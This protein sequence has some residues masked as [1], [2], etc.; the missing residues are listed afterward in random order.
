VSERSG[1]SK[2]AGVGRRRFLKGAAVGAAALV[3]NTPAESAPALPTVRPSVAPP[4]ETAALA[5]M[6]LA[7][8]AQAAVQAS[9]AVAPVP[10]SDFMVDVLKTLDLDY[11]AVNPG[12]AFDGLH[13]SL[14]NYGQNKKPE[15]L[16]CLHEEQAAAISH[17][18]AKAA[19][20][21]MMI[22]VHGTVGLLHASFGIFQAWC[23][24]VPML[25]IVGHNR[26]PTS[27]I[28]RPHSA[29]DMGAIARDYTKWDDEATTLD[30][31]AETAVKAYTYGRTPPMGPTLLVV[32][33]ALQD[34]RI[35]D[36]S[37][38]RIPV[39][40]MPAPPQGDTNAVK[41]AARFLVNAQTPL[42]TIGK[43]A[44]TPKGWDLM[45]EL[46]ELL[47]APVFVGTYGS[48]QDFPNRHKLN[49]RGGAGYRPDVTLGL[50]LNDMSAA[51]RNAR[52]N[53]GKTISICAEYLSQGRN[54]HDYGNYSEVDLA[55]AADA[56]ATLPSLIEEIR[57]LITPDKRTAFDARGVKIAA[58]HHEERVK[59]LEE[60]RFGWDVSPISI[61][62]MIAELG[63]QIKNDDWS[64]GSGHQF[65]GDWQR[66]LLNFDKHH[67]YWGDCGG[68]GIGYDTQAAVGVALANKGTGRLTVAIVGDGDLNFGPGTLWT[69]AHHKIPLLFLV[70]NNRGYQA[71]V[72]IVQRMCSQRG[73]GTDN[74]HIGTTLNN[75][76]I[77]Y[78]KIAQGYGLY[79]E[80]PV[81]DPNKLAPALQRAL[82]RVRAGEPALV[83]VVSQ[84]R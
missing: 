21:P 32:D 45:I 66:V 67:R 6:G 37:R 70:H 72:M 40:T 74:A 12:S 65:T 22:A 17:G 10:A 53:G 81:T 61:Q 49:G 4:T 38:L 73:R 82:A 57:R 28:N 2:N 8:P 54:I 34:S 64:I 7:L 75:P 76:D 80:G 44:R 58:A 41:E 47:Q 13:E 1:K 16:T 39:L 48:W 79:A 27:N 15:M 78:T 60:A 3:T 20:K 50:E 42:I 18:Y 62:R 29:Q 5:E 30:R 11:V 84:A 31:F 71:E 77:D 9:A 51:A 24:R 33:S 63:A 25:V 56:E 23:D 83:D 52:A 19:G 36:R 26:N 46:A 55:I 69:A 43:V 14:I 68:F 59:Q 35:Q